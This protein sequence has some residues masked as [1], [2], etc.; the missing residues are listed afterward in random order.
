MADTWRHLQDAIADRYQIERELGRGGMATV[1]LADDLKHGRKV[2]IK[3]MLPETAAAIGHDRFLREIEIAARL[4]HPHILPLHDS[5]AADGQ[6]YYVMPYIEGES[7]RARIDREKQLPLED[8]LRLTRE[9]ASA[10][11]HAHRHGLIHRD[12]K[13]GNVLLA[14]G[15]ALVADFGLARALSATGAEGL[16]PVGYVV[17]TPAYMAPEQLLGSSDVDGRADLYALGCLVYEMLVGQPPFT[18]SVQRLAHQHVHAEPRPVSDVRPGV[19]AAVV[20]AISKALAKTPADRYATAARF[21]E[22]LAVATTAG[23]T[24]TPDPEGGAVPNNLPRQRTRFIGREREL[25]ECARLLGDARLLTLTGIGGCGKTRLALKLAEHLLATFPDGVWF[26]DLAP[27]LEA[28]RVTLTMA[29]ALGLRE[30]PGMPL[31]NRLAAHLATRRTLIV[32]DN[33]EHVL[34]AAAELAEA[35]LAASANLKLVVTGRE[36][37]GITGEQS[38]ALRS[39]SMPATSATDLHAIEATE[40][41]RLFLDRARLVEPGFSLEAATAPLIA[42]ICRRLDGIPLAIELAAA[43]VKMLSVEEIRARLDDRFRLLTG[44]SKSALS[45]HQ[46]LRAAIGWSF[47]H[48]SHEE[49]RL[50]CRLSVFAGGWTL[51]G[52]ARVAGE[53]TDEFEVLDL[54]TRLGDK[55]LVMPERIEG[56]STRYGMLETVRQYA[57]EQLNQSGETDETRMRHLAFY[58]ALAEEAS[59]KLHTPEQGAWLSRLDRERENLL[60]ALAWCDRAQGEAESGLR[61]VTAIQA[62]WVHLGLPRFRRQFAYAA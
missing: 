46:T 18:G 41:V 15:M 39:L 28:E 5:G 23:P 24:P 16:T 40:A 35:V 60:S 25:A 51:D 54:L 48:L 19:P 1:Y 31:I 45:R 59:L 34:A 7:L 56:G 43:R 14:D 49:Q 12:I 13:P 53:D 27:L 55:S 20:A 9:I 3:V 17:G 44:G 26:V 57:Q 4:T 21:A 62:Y 36:G 11:G 22:A 52:A 30:E 38:L 6:L 50:L 37:L 32:L 58:L 8:A 47:D 10:L 33:C 29:T 61:L 42:E 2:A